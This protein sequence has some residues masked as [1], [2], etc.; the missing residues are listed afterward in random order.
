[1]KRPLQ[2]YLD[3][4]DLDALE[5]WSR[6]R[7]WTKSEAIRA[8]V[9]ALAHSRDRDPLL[10]ASGMIS[11]LPEDASEQFDHYIQETFVAEKAG[12]RRRKSRSRLR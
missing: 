9:R 3:E 4:A 7:G 2:V 12:A 8:A 11:G 6:Q 10:R 5:R 1:M